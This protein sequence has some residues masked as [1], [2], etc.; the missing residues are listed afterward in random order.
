MVNVDWFFISHRLPIAIKALQE[1]Y[2][3]HIATRITNNNQVLEH[4]GLIV[5]P[6]GLHRN[7]KTIISIIKEFIE[8]FYIVRN[9]KPSIVHLVTIKPVLLGGIICKV[10]S[11]PAVVSAVSGMGFIFCNHGL[12][13]LLRRKMV[14]VL[15]FLA[16]SNINQRVIFQNH[17]DMKLLTKYTRLPVNKA[18]FIYGSGVDLTVFTYKPLVNSIPIVMLASR[19]IVEKG[20][21]D[22]IHAAELIKKSR[23]NVRFVLLGKIDSLSPSSI[24]KSEIDLWCNSGIVEYWGYHDKIDSIIPLSNLVVLPSYYGEGLPKVLIEAASCGRP[25]ITTDHPGCRDAIEPG[26]TGRL[27]PIRNPNALANEILS[28]LDDPDLCK[29]MGQAGRKRAEKLFGINQVVNKHMQ[30]YKDM[31]K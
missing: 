22:F 7:R 18:V 10:L 26:V 6:M 16:F 30:I 8:I 24:Q 13:A 25:V 29:R 31:I 3:V 4:A 21:R 1:G 27:V 9:V 19:M 2:E 20:I 28:L 17:N 23:S 11:V 12:I 14:L 15:Y 5:H